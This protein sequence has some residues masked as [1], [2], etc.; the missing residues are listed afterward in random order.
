MSLIST[1]ALKI[2]QNN[3]NTIYSFFLSGEDILKVADI[4]RLQKKEDDALLGYQRGQ[5]KQHI[6]ESYSS[7]MINIMNR[8]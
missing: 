2:K 3:K 6:K 4:S 1:R 8:P 5:V 7:L